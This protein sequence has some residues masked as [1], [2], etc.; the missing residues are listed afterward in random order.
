M[1]ELLKSV[2]DFS[3]NDNFN[4]EDLKIEIKTAKID[5]NSFRFTLE[6]VLNFVLSAAT[7]DKFGSELKKKV[8]NVKTQRYK[9]LGA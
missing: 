3:K 7:I 5:S 4:E 2:I 1:E 6:L 8:S 9:G